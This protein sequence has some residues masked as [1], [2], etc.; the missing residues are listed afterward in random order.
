[1]KNFIAAIICVLAF[2][3][4][5]ASQTPATSGAKIKFTEEA[6]NFGDIKQGEVVKHVFSFKNEGNEPLILS[7]V[8]TTCGCTAS[9]WPKEPIAP[10]KTASIEATFN[11]AGKAGQQNKVLTVFSNSSNGEARISILCNVVV[12]AP[13]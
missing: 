13:N 4:I 9:N 11:S 3:N 12:P 2:A 6:K 10:G 1:M 8:S 7:N 5:A